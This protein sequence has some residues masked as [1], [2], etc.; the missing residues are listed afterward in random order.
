M[1][2]TLGDLLRKD[3]YDTAQERRE[4]VAPQVA[5]DREPVE[6]EDYTIVE[7]EILREKIAVVQTPGFDAAVAEKTG[8][9]CYNA[10]EI[11]RLNKGNA[12]TP[13]FLRFIHKAKK[14]FGGE[15]F[16][17]EWSDEII[18]EVEGKRSPRNKTVRAMFRDYVP[19]NGKR[20]EG[21]S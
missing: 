4:V 6:K 3:G 2:K 14:L 20:L 19:V 18:E 11:R 21:E 9:P 7:S 8:L 15:F 12:K 16:P 10:D 17:P 5:P 13:K 1:K